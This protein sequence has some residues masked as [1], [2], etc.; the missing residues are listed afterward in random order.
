MAEAEKAMTDLSNSVYGHDRFMRQHPEIPKR[1]NWLQREMRGL[2]APRGPDRHHPPGGSRR[3]GPGRH[4]AGGPGTRSWNT[5][6]GPTW[7]WACR[8]HAGSH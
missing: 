2:D 4:G 6:S 5:T 3:H 1:L 8:G 7:G